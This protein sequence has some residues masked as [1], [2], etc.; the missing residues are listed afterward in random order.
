MK[1]AAPLRTV[2]QCVCLVV[3]L[4]QSSRVTSSP[5]RLLILSFQF[6]FVSST[7]QTLTGGSATEILVWVRHGTSHFLFLALRL[8][9]MAVGTAGD[10]Q[11]T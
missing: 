8:L 3:I 9:I 11:R 6:Q 7:R 5:G 1:N 4:I 10:K 2:Y